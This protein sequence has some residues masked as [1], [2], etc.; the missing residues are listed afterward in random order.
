MVKRHLSMLNAPTSWPLERKKGIKWVARPSP[1][2][3]GLHNCI[4]LSLV[5]RNILKYAK[6]K[7]E[8]KKMLNEGKILINKKVRKDQKFPLGI[9]D[10]IEIPLTKE[11]YR[12]LYTNKGM[13]TLHKIPGEESKLK[14][15]KIINKKILKGKKTQLNFNDGR[16]MI[17]D[18]D[19]FKVNDTLI[20]SLGEKVGIKKHV[21]FEKG[22]LVYI[23][24]GKYKGVSGM[25]ENIKTIFT[26]P[27]IEVKTKKETFETSQNFAFVIDDSLSLG[28]PK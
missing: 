2:P 14:P 16:N 13:F 26:N 4:T 17:V 28:E 9:M 3:H 5:L 15:V 27:T 21:K 10:V 8:I 11:H 20:L 22:A 19:D 7:H 12:V 24:E 18:K 6:T 23:I 1:G 25:I